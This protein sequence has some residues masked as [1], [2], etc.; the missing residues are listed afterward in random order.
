MDLS[1]QSDPWDQQDQLEA[2]A[3]TELKANVVPL[4]EM[5]TLVQKESAVTQ[6]VPDILVQKESVVTLVEMDTLEPRESV[7]TMEHQDTVEQRVREEHQEVMVTTVPRENV[8]MP[9]Q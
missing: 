8:V 3:L 7:V 5:D 2:L 9:V 6:V 1:D 4:E